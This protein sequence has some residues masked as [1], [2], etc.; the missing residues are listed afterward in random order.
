MCSQAM[1]NRSASHSIVAKATERFDTDSARIQ[2]GA[3][4]KSPV[5]KMAARDPE[6]VFEIKSPA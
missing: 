1:G 3:A 5:N 2:P 6:F 4:P